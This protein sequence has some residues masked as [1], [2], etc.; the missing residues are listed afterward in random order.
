MVLDGIYFC[1]SSCFNPDPV[2]FYQLKIKL[3]KWSI[4]TI[5]SSLYLL[6]YILATTL[7]S[8]ILVRYLVN[9]DEL[10][11]FYNRIEQSS[12]IQ[13]ERK[14]LR[15]QSKQ[16]VCSL[17]LMVLPFFTFTIFELF[18]FSSSFPKQA[19]YEWEFCFF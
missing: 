7:V 12:A 9:A 17:I 10:P 5:V 15:F 8:Q 11:R 16:I 14:P 19:G 2:F 4:K 6:L 13:M 3:M 1:F 18:F